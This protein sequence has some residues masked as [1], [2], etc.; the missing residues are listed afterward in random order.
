MKAKKLLSHYLG[1]T[2]GETIFFSPTTPAD[3]K[4]IINYI[5]PNKAIGPNSITTIILKEFKTDLSKPLSDIIN[6]SSNKGI[7]PNFLK[8]NYMK[9]QCISH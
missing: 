9:K 1:Q 8:V 5:T 6:T 4:S 7:F 3:I 2:T